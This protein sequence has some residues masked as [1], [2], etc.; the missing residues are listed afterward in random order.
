MGISNFI[1]LYLIVIQ[2]YLTFEQC[3]FELCCPHN[4]RYFSVVNTLVL[5]SLCLVEPG[6]GGPTIT[7]VQI[8]P[9]VV[10]GLTIISDLLCIICTNIRMLLLSEL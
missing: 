9:P 5:K 8:N 4:R 6:Y 1:N 7:Y 2:I 10:Q 3:E